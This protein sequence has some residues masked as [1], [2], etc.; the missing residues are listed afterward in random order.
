MAELGTR[1]LTLKIGGTDYTGTVSNCRITAGDSDADFTSFAD[2]ATGGARTYKLAMT[3]KQDPAA[4][5]LW[6]KVW[7]S[8]GTTVAA[9]VAPNGGTVASATQPTFTGNVIVSEP[10]GDLLGGEANKSASARFTIDVE[11]EFTAKPVRAFT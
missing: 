5:S 1:A 6:D 11:W 9:I 2:A 4:A 7:T 3:L 8:A 10:D